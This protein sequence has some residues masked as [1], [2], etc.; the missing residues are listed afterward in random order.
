MW[1]VCLQKVQNL[2]LFLEPAKDFPLPYCFLESE[3]LTRMLES[4]ETEGRETVPLLLSSYITNEYTL[5]IEGN[6]SKRRT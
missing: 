6:G 1:F 2:E 5:L 3:A 4:S